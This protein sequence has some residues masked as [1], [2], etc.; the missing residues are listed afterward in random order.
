MVAP[1]D[2]PSNARPFAPELLAS[3][4]DTRTGGSPLGC[5]VV[6]SSMMPLQSLSKESHSS[7]A[8]GKIDGTASSQSLPQPSAAFGSVDGPRANTPSPSTSTRSSR[9]TQAL[10]TQESMVQGSPSSQNC[11]M[12]SEHTPSLHD[13]VPH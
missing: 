3:S 5:S 4:G 10:A 13:A 11:T 2:W 7:T 8:P 1:N 12:S 6:P 9:D